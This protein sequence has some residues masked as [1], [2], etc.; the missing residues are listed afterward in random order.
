MYPNIILSN[1]LQP[2]AI[3]NEQ[4]CA[5]C[6][7]NKDANDCK[8]QLDWEWKGDMYPLNK[9][10]FERVK[11]QLKVEIEGSTTDRNFNKSRFNKEGG[12][13]ASAQN[14]FEN[15]ES[16]DKLLKQRV[17]DFSRMHY[18]HVKQS[19]REPRTD[20]VC[21]RENPFYVDTVR[22]FRDRRYEFKRL[23][24]VWLGKLSEAKKAGGDAGEIETCNN[25][26]AL[27]ESL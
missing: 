21:M 7:F 22:D 6:T 19:R 13:D 8:R 25:R 9:Q 16:F 15:S 1:R 27:Y 20:T 2:V 12:K 23:V 3:V 14:L 26:V 17:K 10:E 5:G 24:K 4:I 11:L 18:N